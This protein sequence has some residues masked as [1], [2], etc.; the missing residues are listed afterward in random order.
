MT[1]FN[2]AKT[3]LAQ[4]GRATRY[5]RNLQFGE[6][7]IRT[8]S[9]PALDI[10]SGAQRGVGKMPRQSARGTTVLGEPAKASL[11]ADFRVLLHCLPTYSGH[12]AGT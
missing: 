5:C 4:Q 9:S 3:K 11:F 12:P 8:T 7:S 2:I 6:L 10:V 1:V